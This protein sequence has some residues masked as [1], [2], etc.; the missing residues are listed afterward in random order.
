MGSA[1]EMKLKAT[2]N[3]TFA[4]LTQIKGIG[5]RV[6]RQF[7]F[8]TGHDMFDAA[9]S[10]ILK[11][12]KGGR[13]YRIRKRPGAPI[14]RHVAS[15]PFETHAQLSGEA[16]DSIGFKIHG[17]SRMVFG[18]GASVKKPAPKHGAFLEFG[19]IGFK[20]VGP[21]AARPSLSDAIDRMEGRAQ[22]NLDV[23]MDREFKF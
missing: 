19:T 7:W 4:E 11:K 5:R 1:I 18:Y 17:S 9:R 16:R 15:A 8:L 12:P 10:E 2:S 14:R 13:T 22:R 21:M 6:I 23:A 3:K 20:K